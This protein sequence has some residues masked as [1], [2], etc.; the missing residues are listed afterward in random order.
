MKVIMVAP[1]FYPRIGGLEN[2]VYNIS[3]VLI[4]EYGVAVSVIC[5]NWDREG[6]KE[7]TI[8]GMKVYR[9]PYLLKL[10]TTPIN[11]FWYR[12][13]ASIISKENPDIINGHTPVP[14]IADVAARIAHK[15]R[16]PFI[17][18]YHNDLVGRNLLLEFLSTFYYHWL[19]F[20]TFKISQKIIVTSAYYAES[21]PYLKNSA[22]KLEVVPV[23]VDTS[24]FNVTQGASKMGSRTVLFV[25]QLEKASQHKGLDY[26]ISAMKMVNDTVK[27]VELV[28][29]GKGNYINHYRKL[30]Q[31][32]GV[33]NK[34]IF[35]GFV[36]DDELPRYYN[37]SNV[38][39]LPSYNRAEGCGIVLIEAQACGKPVIGTCVGGIPYAISDRQTG[40]LVPPKDSDC[41]AQAI[42][43]LLKDEELANRLGE[44]GYKRVRDTFTWKKS[45][46]KTFE[47]YLACLGLGMK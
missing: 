45:A 21:S 40:L 32:S 16:I 41:L 2:Y 20:R 5:S 26:L 42:V 36:P 22:A 27:D 31:A 10:S 44:N 11:P 14:Y 4:R 25:G 34:I 7:E 23:G 28:V 47:V 13:I 29:V 12:R 9:L 24:K 1:Y 15:R 19:G 18:T 8:E 38:V 33:Q 6:Y 43:K 46:E 39:V 17:L 37:Q 30:A 3:K 35:V